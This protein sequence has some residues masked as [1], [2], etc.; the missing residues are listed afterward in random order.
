MSSKFHLQD[1][2]LSILEQVDFLFKRAMGKVA[3]DVQRPFYQETLDIRPAVLYEQIWNNQVPTQA[4]FDLLGDDASED[5]GTDDYG[6]DL[7]GSVYGKTSIINTV[8]RKYIKLKLRHVPGAN[9]LAFHYPASDTATD[10]SIGI[11]AFLPANE[12]PFQDVIPFNYDPNGTY[13]VRLYKDISGEPE[14]PFGETGGEWIIN[15]ERATITFFELDNVTNVT[16]D[17]PPLI[18]FYR[19]VGGKGPGAT[20]VTGGGDGGTGGS[21]DPD[22]KQSFNGGDGT[23]N[24]EAHAICIDDSR[25]SL[26][27]LPEDQCSYSLQFGP[28]L[29]GSWRIITVSNGDG[30][31]S[32]HF[33]YRTNTIDEWKT[34]MH[35]DPADCSS[36]C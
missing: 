30:T 16:A 33:Q 9:G 12:S 32:L 18:S 19:Y 8:V 21:F 5:L 10:P 23:C 22:M 29:C 4:P 31:T 2:T 24:D 11:T 3:V 20:G 28:D 6:F 13:E 27:S 14:I 15:H 35:L 25:G 1:G 36:S 7:K 17:N 26:A 34:K